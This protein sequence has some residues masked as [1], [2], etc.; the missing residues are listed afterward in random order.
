[1]IAFVVYSIVVDIFL[2]VVF[3]VHSTSH[4]IGC[5]LGYCIGW[6][7]VCN[8]HFPVSVGF[9]V[10]VSLFLDPPYGASFGGAAASSTFSFLSRH[11]PV[12]VGVFR[13]TPLGVNC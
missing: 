9:G 1:M 4:C 8:V 2:V 7:F 13:K 10:G 3:V 6:C 5:R 11:V 12:L